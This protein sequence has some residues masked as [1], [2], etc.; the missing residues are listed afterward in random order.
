MKIIHLIALFLFL[1]TE[2]VF[3][4]Y[5]QMHKQKEM[6][7]EIQKVV[8]EIL[9]KNGEITREDYNNFWNKVGA[10]SPNEKE[11]Y[12]TSFK[13]N[14]LVIQEYNREMWNCAEKNWLASKTLPCPKAKEKIENMKKNMVMK[15]QLAMFSTIEEGF[16]SILKASANKTD[17]V[18]KDGINIGKISLETIRKSRDDSD[19]FLKKF[20]RILTMN[21]EE[22]K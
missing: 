7:Q 17:I 2:V 8:H 14:F 20:N 11:Q 22:K 19:K 16:N 9:I 1:S 3:A 4:Q 18:S 15:E 13:K 21:F 5:N 6:T 10:N 12:I